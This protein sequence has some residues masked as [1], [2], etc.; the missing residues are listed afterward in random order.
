MIE[1]WELE[2]ESQADIEVKETT[3]YSIDRMWR[4]RRVRANGTINSNNLPITISW[5]DNIE[6]VLVKA[7][8][9]GRSTNE[10]MR[11]VVAAFVHEKREREHWQRC[12]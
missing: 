5:H 4:E 2:E 11:C 1:E 7:R 12:P 9:T 8:R 10:L 3:Q 6:N